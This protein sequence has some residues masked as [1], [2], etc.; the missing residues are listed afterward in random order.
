MFRKFIHTRFLDKKINIAIIISF[1]AIIIFQLCFYFSDDVKNCISKLYKFLYQYRVLFSSI[2]AYIPLNFI[3]KIFLK[4][5]SIKKKNRINPIFSGEIDKTHFFP[6]LIKQEMIDNGDIIPIN[7]RE[8]FNEHNHKPI[9][10]DRKE[11]C[12]NITK[13]IKTGLK[14][15]QQYKL[16]CLFLIGT[17]GSGK[18][19]IIKNFIAKSLDN[20]GIHHYIIRD[21]YNDSELI[22]RKL[23]DGY[24]VIIMDQ[25][26]YSINFTSVYN[27]IKEIATQ[28]YHSP[29]FIFSFP[30]E[31][32][33]MIFAQF[34]NIL[35]NNINSIPYFIECDKHDINELTE[36]VSLFTTEDILSVKQCI[37]SCKTSYENTNSF[38]SVLKST[39]YKTETVFLSSILYKISCGKSP[40]VEFS[41]LSYIYELFSQ[42]INL[43]MEFY[44]DDPNKIIELYLNNWIIK[45][46]NEQ[47]AKIILYLLSNGKTYDSDDLKATTFENNN[48]FKKNADNLNII[49]AL[50]SNI[51]FYIDNNAYNA[52]PKIKTVHDY[53][54]QKIN[55]YCFANVSNDIKQ[56]VNHYIKL[57]SSD[58]NYNSTCSNKSKRN[59]IMRRYNRYYNSN[60]RNIT[61]FFV[62]IVMIATFLI[63]IYKGVNTSSNTQNIIYVFLSINCL[64]SIYYIYSI[65]AYSLRIL[66]LK[67]YIMDSII[68]ASVV[69]LCY[70]FP[71]I[72]GILLGS[73]ILIHGLTLWNLH[74]ITADDASIYFK[75]KGFLYMIIGILIVLLGFH[76][77]S[78]N[79]QK[80]DCM[81][82]YNVLYLMYISMCNFTHIKHEYII[83][84]IGK[85]NT[86]IITKNIE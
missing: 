57:I 64:L 42:E 34:S 18:S 68:G 77:S 26:E 37:E 5:L 84:K 29:F 70:V 36:L 76:Y 52:E 19:T 75:N 33:H 25:F 78:L 17:S 23:Q 73:E 32:L 11:Q 46:P 55:E 40:L 45:F 3:I 51:F 71:K 20:E 74:K 12:E 10:I 41:I 66:P 7:N 38:I 48:C 54:A 31:A 6:G 65:I 21:N 30:P 63:S 14:N 59:E 53:A 69:I 67:Y 50:K 24:V 49:D 80:V 47:T 83:N 13:Y 4:K 1:F 8:T 44:I 27:N 16:N 82:I 39:N 86:I 85:E 60:N 43:N 28:S 81:F 72:W 62:T 15:K 35:S 79:P 61:T 9:Y 58:S 56:N 22:K 2:I